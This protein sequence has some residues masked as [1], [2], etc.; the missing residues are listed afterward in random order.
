MKKFDISFDDFKDKVMSFRKSRQNN[1]LLTTLTF[2]GI[3][4]L[5]TLCVVIIVKLCFCKKG[6]EVCDCCDDF[7][8]DCCYT[9]D[10]DFE[11][12]GSHA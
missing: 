6:Y 9:D 5:I 12:D 8:D 3:L 10:F 2:V 4:A 11:G 1:S 7:E